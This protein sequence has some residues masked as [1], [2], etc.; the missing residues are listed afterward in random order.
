MFGDDKTNFPHKLLLTNREVANL[1]KASYLS[2]DIKLSKTQLSRVVQLGG[3]L[4]RLPGPLLKI[5]LPF[6]K[7][8]ITLVAKSILIPLGLNAAASSADAG[9]HKKILEFGR[10]LSSAPRAT[11]LI[12]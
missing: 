6:M 2:A 11:T 5:G 4:I 1:R 3:F 9:I 8:I 12:I 10:P 7:N